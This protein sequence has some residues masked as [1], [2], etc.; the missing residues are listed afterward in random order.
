MKAE[1][2]EEATLDSEQRKGTQRHRQGA[3]APG[4]LRADDES[5][6]RERGGEAGGNDTYAF[7][8]FC[9]TFCPMQKFSPWRALCL[10]PTNIPLM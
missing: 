1:K 5:G 4:N 6:P 10:M 3:S 8:C 2:Q 7:N 9:S